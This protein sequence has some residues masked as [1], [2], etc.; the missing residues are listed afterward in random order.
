MSKEQES[1]EGLV[2]DKREDSASRVDPDA[3]VAGKKE[4]TPPL[5]NENICDLILPFLTAF[6][7]SNVCIG[8]TKALRDAATS[9]EQLWRQR[10]EEDFSL[11]R[12]AGI[13]RSQGYYR[14]LYY[15]VQEE[16]IMEENLICGGH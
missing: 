10:L 1:K 15:S 4:M 6:D 14:R 13:T 5:E 12:S 8:G 2:L 7:L 16:R 3:A 11:K 9:A